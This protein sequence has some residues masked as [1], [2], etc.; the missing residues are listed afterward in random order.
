[1]QLLLPGYDM[2]LIDSLNFLQM[3]LSKFPVTFGL[4]LNN[5]SKGDFPFKFNITENQD[6]VGTISPVEFYSPETKCKEDRERIVVWHK[7]MVKKNF[8]FD[9][10]KEIL[11]YCSQDVTILRLCCLEFRK[12]FFK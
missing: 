8:V 9:F 11:V 3:P 10:Q 4:D 12:M 6:Y 1:M 7:D 2:R 5:F